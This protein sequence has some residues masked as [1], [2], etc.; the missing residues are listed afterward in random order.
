MCE[1][2]NLNFMLA[3]LHKYKFFLEYNFLENQNKMYK[4][5]DQL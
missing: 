4:L 3:S 5:A 2:V 1:V